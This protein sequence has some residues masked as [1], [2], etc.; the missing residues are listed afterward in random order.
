M[1]RLLIFLMFAIVPFTAFADI[2]TTDSSTDN[3][4]SSPAKP[5]QKYKKMKKDA[6]ETKKPD[7][8]TYGVSASKDATPFV[9]MSEEEFNILQKRN[10]DDGYREK[11]KPP[12]KQMAQGIERYLQ[13]EGIK[14]K[15]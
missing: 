13:S 1:S 10:K 8:E 11:R 2:D 5:K 15:P 14:L 9:V 6:V 3:Q 7:V 12:T 4:M